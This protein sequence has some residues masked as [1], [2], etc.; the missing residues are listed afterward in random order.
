LKS[1]IGCGY[2]QRGG[3]VKWRRVFFDESGRSHCA[4]FLER[5]G[6]PMIRS[7]E[8]ESSRRAVPIA[9]FV[10]AGQECESSPSGMVG[11]YA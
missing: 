3:E 11:D 4:F 8:G 7:G 2:C 1:E 5:R 10:T 6:T 9:R